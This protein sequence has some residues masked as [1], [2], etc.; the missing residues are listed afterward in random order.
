MSSIPRPDVIVV[1]LGAVGSAALYQLARRG[2][3]AVGID[4]FTPPHARGS[5]H[6]E[7][8]ITRLALGEGPQ[9]V[10]FARRAHQIWRELEDATGR[11]LLRQVGCLISG[12]AQRGG[13]HGAG[14]FLAQTIAVARQ[15]GIAHEVL[16]SAELARRFPPLRWRGDER[17]CLEPGGGF[18]HPEACVE[19]QLECARRL[20]ANTVCDERVLAWSAD[21]SGVTVRT[22]RATYRAAHL[23]LAAGAWLP[24]LVAAL[25][26]Q[27]RVYRQV[28]YWFRPDGD[29]AWFRAGA[30]PV[31]VRLP[32]T[33]GA[34]FYGFPLA[35]E[36]AETIKLAGEQFEHAA[37]PDAIDDTVS[38]AEQAAMYAL[39]APHL[40]IAAPCVRAV[41]CKYTV[42]PDFGFVID[43]VPESE[44]VWLASAC[45]GHGFKHSAAVGEA[46]AEI[47]AGGSTRFDLSPFSLRR[48]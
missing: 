32:D 25:A 19:A 39:A 18:V 20:G 21:G 41:A 11:T 24:S 1:G 27:A 48:W 26:A 16:D 33:D 37:A 43:H 14:D 9:Y 2:V 31:F 38:A 29:P 36:D 34:M 47:A 15:H 10:Q 23:I 45:S 35:D 46:L 40:R 6:G 7:T 22:E 28:M 42:T 12:A 4:R 8:R 3:A 17:G 30:L 13:A 44:R 5:S